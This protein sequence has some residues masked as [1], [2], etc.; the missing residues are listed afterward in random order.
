M[1]MAILVSFYSSM[2]EQNTVNI[3]MHVQ[4][5]LRARFNKFIKAG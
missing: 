2:V 1:Y 4:F 3:P 5:M